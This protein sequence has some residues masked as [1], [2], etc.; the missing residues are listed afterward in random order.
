MDGVQRTFYLSPL[1]TEDVGYMG[2][3]T[4]MILTHTSKEMF[5][6]GWGQN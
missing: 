6:E 2:C 4:K 1:R 3:E 5:K